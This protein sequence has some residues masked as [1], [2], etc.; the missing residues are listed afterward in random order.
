[1]KQ[2]PSISIIT[3]TYNCAATLERTLHS[4]ETQT[5]THFEHLIID[6]AS[7]DGTPEMLGKTEGVR[8]ISEPDKGIY[9]A[10][11]KGIRMAEGEWVIFMNAGDVFASDDTLSKVFS[12]ERDADVIYGDVIKGDSIKK[13]E[14]P[15]NAHRMYFCHQSA[16][17]RTSC[18]KEFP[19]DIQHRMSADFKQMKQLYLAGKTF[20]QL[21]FPIA[22]FDTSGVSNAQRSKG[23]YDNIQVIR[24]VDNWKERLR[25]LPRLLFTYWMC[26]LRGA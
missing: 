9:D 12:V 7:T 23:L 22:V 25:L 5:F 11:N 14:P 3:V 20:M 4:I 6:G 26:R 24:E 18:L 10:M 1:M 16:F 19:F 15:H 8:W 21:D 13:A 17:V 2:N